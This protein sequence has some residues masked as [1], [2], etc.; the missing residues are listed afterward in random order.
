M[1][2]KIFAQIENRDGVAVKSEC[3]GTAILDDGRVSA[4]KYNA[5][6]RT[7]RKVFP[8]LKKG[9]RLHLLAEDGGRPSFSG[10]PCQYPFVRFQ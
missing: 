2:T 3:I 10:Y 6:V 9:Q 7:A 5:L 8:D 1:K 4:R